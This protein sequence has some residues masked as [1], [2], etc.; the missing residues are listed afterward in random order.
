MERALAPPGT[1]ELCFL[2]AGAAVVAGALRLSS[3]IYTYIFFSMSY[4]EWRRRRDE[5]GISVKFT[6]SCGVLR[7]LHDLLFCTE[8]MHLVCEACSKTVIDTYYCPSCLTSIFVAVAMSAKNRCDNCAECPNC[9]NN[10]SIVTSHPLDTAKPTATES[11]SKSLSCIFECDFC[12]WSSASIGLVGK[13]L[14]GLLKAVKE[15]DEQLRAAPEAELQDLV[16]SY[17]PIDEPPH[18]DLKLGSGVALHSPV[19][20]RGP[21]IFTQLDQALQAKARANWKLASQPI[22]QPLDPAQQQVDDDARLGLDLLPL[23]LDLLPLCVPWTE[24]AVSAGPTMASGLNAGNAENPAKVIPQRKQLLVKLAYRCR[25]CPTQ[26]Y[27]LKPEPNANNVDFEMFCPA[28]DR[29]P[30][31]TLS[32]PKEPLV[33]GTSSSLVLHLRNP[34]EEP[35]QVSLS[36]LKAPN[37][38]G[39]ETAARETAG[40]PDKNTS[41]KETGS[42]PSPDGKSAVSE[43]APSLVEGALPDLPVSTALVQLAVEDLVVDRY[44]I[45]AEHEAIVLAGD[46]HKVRSR[47]PQDPP[48]VVYR[49][50]NQVGVKLDITPNTAGP[51]HFGLHCIVSGLPETESTEWEVPFTFYVDVLAGSAVLPVQS[52]QRSDSLVSP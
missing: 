34:L 37:Q 3:S 14:R 46:G 2:L 11:T 44:E 27:V 45:E 8:C 36:P 21:H 7:P 26:Q 16:K 18:R 39:G 13:D 25:T 52:R 41:Q 6:C 43:P 42:G 29:L 32:I 35:V 47:G 28:L 51:V 31:F 5:S 30:C 33:V 50:L 22:S 9:T 4:D 23:R 38:A 49:E 20:R 48:G 15:R 19:K 17:S 12:K 1:R 24:P 40:Q 10:L